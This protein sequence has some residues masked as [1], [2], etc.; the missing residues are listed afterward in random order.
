MFLSAAITMLML[1]LCFKELIGGDS[2]HD[3]SPFDQ[4]GL[5]SQELTLSSNLGIHRSHLY[6]FAFFSYDREGGF[7]CDKTRILIIFKCFLKLK[8]KH[9]ETWKWCGLILYSKYVL[10]LTLRYIN[11]LIVIVNYHVVQENR[12][13]AG[14]FTHWATLQLFNING[15]LILKKPYFSALSF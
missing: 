13:M 3:S 6:S 8:S 4:L 10:Y 14:V 1:M 9:S 7:H 11:T 15:H 5:W 12:H 2:L